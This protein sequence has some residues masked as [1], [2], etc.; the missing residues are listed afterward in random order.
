MTLGST[1]TSIRSTLF[2]VPDWLYATLLL[3]CAAIVALL[4]F[5]MLLRALRRLIGPK[6]A[7]L[8]SLIT[9]THG[10]IRLALVIFAV[11]A[12][13]PAAPLASGATRTIAQLLLVAFIVLVGWSALTAID[14]A[15]QFYLRRFKLDSEDNLLARKHLTQVNILKRSIN[16]LVVLITAATAL[17]TFEAVR[18]YGVS[19]IASAGA[20]GIVVGLAARPVL[21]NLI[22]G[23]QIAITQ[24]IRIDDAVVVENEWGWIEEIGSTY[25]VI[26]LWDW[27]RLVVP[28]SYFIEKPFQNWTRSSAQIIGTV[29]LNV[30]YTVPVERVRAKLEDIVKASPLWD[31]GVI[32]LQVVEAERDTIQLR[33]LVSARNSPR[34]WDLRCEVREKLIAFLQTEYPHALPRLRAEIVDFDAGAGRQISREETEMRRGSPPRHETQAS[35]A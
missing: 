1:L 18:Q 12:V 24:P 32:N 27:R 35:T 34:V 14:L 2:W 8:Q 23:I 25:V 30:D 33:A 13:L 31:G 29:L 5:R 28:L 21:A 20:A 19:L 26:K 9:R 15:A 17:M 7:F 16:I 22:A 4:L 11:A 3:A 6:Q 10:P